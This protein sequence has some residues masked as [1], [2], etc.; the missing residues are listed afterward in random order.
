MKKTKITIYRSSS[1]H[2]HIM[3]ILVWLG[4]VA[5]VFVLF[6][7]R[8][9]K[10]EVLGIAQ[11]RMHR[12]SAPVDSQLK[13]VS[14]ELF[15]NV[16]KGQMLA[17]LD[18]SHLNAQMATIGAEIEHLTS[19]LVSIQDT[20][21][22]DATNRQTDAIASQRRFYIDVEN[23]RIRM[24][25]QKTLIETD[26]VAAEDL[27]VEVKIAAELLEKKAIAPYEL[28]KARAMYN[29]VAK[30]IEENQYLLTQ[31]EQDLQQALQ[32]RDEFARHQTVHPSINTALET[33]RK[34]IAIQEKRIVELSVQRQALRIISPVDGRVVKIQIRA[35]QM[36]SQRSGEDVLRKPGEVVLAGDPI[37][38]IAET[39]PTEIV[40][41]VG[42]GQLAKVKETMVVQLIKN[43]EPV[44]IASSQVIRLSP[45][46][47]LMP[48][49]LWRN[50]NI[51]QWGQ[52]ILIKIP[53][54]LKL[55][56][57]ETMGIRGI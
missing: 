35:N 42:Q 4:A 8:S 41:Y 53:P 19:Q 27:A 48:Q 55:L 45:T 16:R 22:A 37:L 18:D 31:S 3:P 51:A 54:D 29:V 38:V 12:I 39:E 1:L 25:E 6:R 57:G 46:M 11:G 32:R 9:Q 21:L 26:K 20:M 49:Q 15:D 13:I 34:Q 44:Q 28:Q 36:T 43:T 56:P 50:P 2:R 5:C 47:E 23:A 7:H 24:L 10:F 52:A 14:V 17:V 30:R 40:A 33:I